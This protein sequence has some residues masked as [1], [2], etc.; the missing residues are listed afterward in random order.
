MPSKD[1]VKPIKVAELFAGVGGFRLGLEGWHGKSA[2]SGYRDEWQSP[3]QVVWS[4][5]WEPSTKVQHASGVYE[6]RFGS[7][8]HVNEN[9]FPYPTDKIAD[10]DM[11]VGGFPCQ[12]YSVART[13]NQAEGLVGKK[14]VLWWAIHRIL[15][16]K[17][18][19][20]ASVVFL[21]NVDRL[22]KSPAKQRGRDFAIM[23]ASLSDLGYIVEWRVINAANYGMPQRRRRVFIIAYQN[24]SAIGKEFL[25]LNRPADWLLESGPFARAFPVKPAGTPSLVPFEIDG[26][27]E[28]LSREFPAS[29]FGQELEVNPD[30]GR[31]SPFENSGVMVNRSVFT[32]KTLPIEEPSVVLG[33]VVFTNGKVQIPDSYYLSPETLET[34]RYLKGAKKENWRTSKTGFKYNYNEG[35][36]PFPD[37]LDRPARTIITGEGGATPSRFKHVVEI[38]S[39]R[40][41]RLI[42]EELE[43]LNMFPPGH[44]AVEGISDVKR[45]FFMGNALVVGVV[46]RVARELAWR[47]G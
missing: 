29:L 8:G 43:K 32:F 20:R 12:D 15:K 9:I 5:Q 10:H 26:D 35:P 1:M 40:P 45:A 7:E 4:N 17:E 11:L 25:E 16:E 38:V 24:E 3:F 39:G 27:L 37:P 30:L 2:T 31:R 46:E 41:R 13:L 34:W 18:A 22:L 42:P 47:I 14:G 28:L 23:L 6:A 44:T 36:L 21:E 33:D 19:K